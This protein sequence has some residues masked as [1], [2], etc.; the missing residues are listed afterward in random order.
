MEDKFLFISKIIT[1]YL[2]FDILE[3]MSIIKDDNKNI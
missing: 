2:F 1:N 3:N